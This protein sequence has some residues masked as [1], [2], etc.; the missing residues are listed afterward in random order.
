MTGTAVAI[1]EK[2]TKLSFKQDTARWVDELGRVCHKRVTP[3]GI[4]SSALHVGIKNPQIFDCEPKSIFLALAKC[5]RLG[6]YPGGGGMALVP[7]NNK[8]KVKGEWTKVLQLE[9]WPEY[10]GLKA[11]AIRQRM[12]AAMEEHCVKERDDFDFGLGLEPY[13][14]HRPASTNRGALTGAYSVIRLSGGGR[15]FHYMPIED[16]EKI[17]ATSRSWGPKDY[18]VCPDWYAMKTVVRDWM[19]RQ[20]KEGAL[21]E[22]LALDDTAPAALMDPET[23]E[24]LESGEP[25]G[26]LA[27][28][29]A[30]ED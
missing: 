29:D 17:R 16:I 8:V 21:G 22:A 20:P 2:M 19:G 4:V 11:L 18:P 3:E 15:T 1:P 24:V 13:L 14:R 9:A 12:I 27:A 5:A 28:G 10:Q 26:A 25:V 7:L 23:G 30:A 6:L